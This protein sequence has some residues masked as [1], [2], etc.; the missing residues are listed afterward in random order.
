MIDQSDIKPCDGCVSAIN[1]IESYAADMLIFR[2]DLN[3]SEKGNLDWFF[4][5]L[6][7]C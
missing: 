6:H 7:R 2:N 1:Q 3:G 4:L 5:C